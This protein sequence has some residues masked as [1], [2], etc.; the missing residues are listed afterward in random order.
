MMVNLSHLQEFSRMPARHE[1]WRK[2]V[3]D[4]RVQRGAPFTGLA[5]A[6]PETREWSKPPV[7]MTIKR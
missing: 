2:E 7:A 6:R 4:A 3:P 5:N 1:L